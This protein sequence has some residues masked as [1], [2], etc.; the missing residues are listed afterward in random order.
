MSV[1]ALRVDS[2]GVS[3]TKS[4]GP[5]TPHGAPLPQTQPMQP[6]LGA[7]SHGPGTGAQPRSTTPPAMAACTQAVPPG[8]PPLGQ[9]LVTHGGS[10]FV[11]GHSHGAT[12]HEPPESLEPSDPPSGPST[13]PCSTT[14]LLSQAAS[15]SH[16]HVTY[17]N[18]IMP[19]R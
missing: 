8:Q 3:Q 9:L 4:V 13:V 2:V 18:V 14:L 16:R 5:S 7:P 1:L 10:R 19:V 6:Q 12:E 17:R 11:V 15:A